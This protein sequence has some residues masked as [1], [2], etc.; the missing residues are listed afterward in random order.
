MTRVYNWIP[1]TG[2][3]VLKIVPLDQE[4]AF[5]RGPFAYGD[6]MNVGGRA[7]DDALKIDSFHAGTWGWCLYDGQTGR[8]EWELMA[9]QGAFAELVL[10]IHNADYGHRVTFSVDSGKCYKQAKR[11]EVSNMDY[12]IEFDLSAAAAGR[13]K[14]QVRVIHDEPRQRC[15]PGL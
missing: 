11:V 1:V 12:P 8:M 6:G 10:G 3:G 5:S 4:L 2:S 15:D 14:V 9:K 13:E 7:L